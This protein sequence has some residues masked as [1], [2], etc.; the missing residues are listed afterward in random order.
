M[1]ARVRLKTDVFLGNSHGSNIVWVVLFGVFT[2]L[3]GSGWA[4]PFHR[5]MQHAGLSFGAGPG[6][7]ILGSDERHDL[8][9]TRLEWGWVLTDQLAESN[10]FAGHLE[11]VAQAFG[12][13]Q[14]RPENAY[15]AGLLPLV[16]YNFTGAHGI[17]PFVELGAGV[18]LT[19]IGPPDLS[20]IFQFNEQLG[21]GSHFFLRP[22][23]AFTVDYRF[24]HFSNAGISAPNQGVN[25]NVISLGFARFF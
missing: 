24:I 13:V 16:R 3:R 9:L 8:A 18:S 12:G 15:V 5:D 14:F 17:V 22:N 25:S 4:G 21:I 19:D 6:A 10:C 2:L 1:N 23:L 7:A 11:L 20:G